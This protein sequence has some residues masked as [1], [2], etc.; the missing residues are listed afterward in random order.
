MQRLTNCRIILARIGWIIEHRNMPQKQFQRSPVLLPPARHL[1]AKAKFRKRNCGD[2]YL[3][4]R[5]PRQPATRIFI[6]LRQHRHARA[7]IQQ[8]D[9]LVPFLPA[10][11]HHKPPQRFIDLSRSPRM[12]PLEA[13]ASACVNADQSRGRAVRINS[14]P[15]LATN[16]SSPSSSNSLG[17]RTAWFRPFL[18]SRAV[19]FS[20][21]AIFAPKKLRHMPMAYA[22]QHQ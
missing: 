20:V 21:S 17:I 12:K 16:T 11:A 9:R 2:A 15:R 6:C 8:V 10:I 18:N 1:Q 22:A 5:G 4:H 13:N 7:G 14:S 3:P 19:F